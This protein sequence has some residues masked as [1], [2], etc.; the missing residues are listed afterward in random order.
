[1]QC[2]VGATP[3]PTD[4]AAAAVKSP[5]PVQLHAGAKIPSRRVVTE[6][7]ARRRL[8]EGIAQL[9]ASKRQQAERLAEFEARVSLEQRRAAEAREATDAER[10]R[11]Q[12]E[13]AAFQRQQAVGKSGRCSC[14]W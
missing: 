5:A 10:R 8:A 4:A 1:M 11:L 9:E 12:A 14:P 2:A 13:R 3:A 7:G 6:A